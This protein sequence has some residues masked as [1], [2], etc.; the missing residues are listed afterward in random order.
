MITSSN[1]DLIN[2]NQN[3]E[4]IKFQYNNINSNG[5]H[6]KEDII[7]ENESNQKKKSFNNY[8]NY[9]NDDFYLNQNIII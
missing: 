3:N 8:D 6:L 5:N 7:M 2:D 4:N 1:N 9:L